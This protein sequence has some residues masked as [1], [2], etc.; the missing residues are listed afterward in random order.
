MML[1]CKKCLF[2]ILF[3]YS[4]QSSYCQKYIPK[5][6]YKATWNYAGLKGKVKNATAKFYYLIQKDSLKNIVKQYNTDTTEDGLF[7]RCIETAQ[8]NKNGLREKEIIKN[9]KTNTEIVNPS[10]SFVSQEQDLI[11]NINS[12]SKDSSTANNKF[13][14]YTHLLIYDSLERLVCVKNIGQNNENL[15]SADFLYNTNNDLITSKFWGL[16]YKLLDEYNNRYDKYDSLIEIDH[17][18][19]SIDEFNTTKVSYHKNYYE[20]CLYLNNRKK[21]RIDKNTKLENGGY[22]YQLSYTKNSTYEKY[23]VKQVYNKDN[24]K[25]FEEVVNDEGKMLNQLTLT[26][27]KFNRNK[28]IEEMIFF[29]SL[30]NEKIICTHQYQYDALGNILE[31]KTYSNGKLTEL[32]KSEFEYYE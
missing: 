23:R 6:A 5:Q 30:K 25:E 27:Y 21:Y 16:N 15:F 4:L 31:H 20:S 3:L 1:I 28:D 32:M 7:L 26:S 11:P 9:I 2:I 22:E 8:F 14:T 19:F 24:L 18:I 12:L 10:E 17:Y 13:I 29:D